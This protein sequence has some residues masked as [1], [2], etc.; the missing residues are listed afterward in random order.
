MNRLILATVLAFLILQAGVASAQAPISGVTDATWKNIRA[1]MLESKKPAESS[2]EELFSRLVIAAI[3]E[4]LSNE[5]RNR[6]IHVAN[7]PKDGFGV[8]DN[9]GWGWLTAVFALA[10]E[11]QMRLIKSLQDKDV[12]KDVEIRALKDKQ[13]LLE[14][15]IAILNEILL[16]TRNSTN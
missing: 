14:S 16:K 10:E 7:I 9:D 12:Q 4:S 3:G 15:Q 11:H 8:F 5:A 2:G 1:R 6:T 13:T